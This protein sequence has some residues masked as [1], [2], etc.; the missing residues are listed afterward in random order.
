[1][2]AIRRFRSGLDSL[3]FRSGSYGVDIDIVSFLLCDIK[4]EFSKAL[5]SIII[6]VYFLRKGKPLFYQN[7]RKGVLAML[8]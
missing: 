7:T 6:F 4:R 2:L 1:M 8:V 5:K 3:V